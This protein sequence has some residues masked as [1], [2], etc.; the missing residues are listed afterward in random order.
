MSGRIVPA[1]TEEW[2]D[3]VVKYSCLCLTYPSDI[4]PA[5]SGLATRF[6]QIHGAEYLAGL[7]HNSQLIEQLAWYT[8]TGQM[9]TN[10]DRLPAYRA[11]TFSCASVHAGVAWHDVY[12]RFHAHIQVRH[13]QCTLKSSNPFGEVNARYISVRGRVTDLILRQP[14]TKEGQPFLS[15]ENGDRLALHFFP[16]KPMGQIYF[17]VKEI[18]AENE[19]RL[20]R[21]IQWLAKAETLLPDFIRVFGLRICTYTM[22][23]EDRF[24]VL[25]KSA[26]VPGA[27]ERLG[28]IYTWGKV[29][30]VE[31]K[32]SL[33][34]LLDHWDSTPVEELMIV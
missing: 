13:A 23:E 10:N 9:S 25:V 21:S 2:Q 32:R 27:Y 28:L 14:A 26:Y 15:F 20:Q 19:V 16:D 8:E 11:P 1:T 33:K 30:Q 6:H 31:E 3:A 5:L 12:G 7:W 22:F 34:Q 4:L 17:R 24:L 29:A 18:A